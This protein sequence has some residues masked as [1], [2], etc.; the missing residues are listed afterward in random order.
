MLITSTIKLNFTTLY[1]IRQYYKVRVT[2]TI[3][4]NCKSDHINQNMEIHRK[5]NLNIGSYLYNRM[6]FRGFTRQ[7]KID[8]RSVCPRA[9]KKHL[10]YSYITIRL[11]L[12]FGK[13]FKTNL[14]FYFQQAIKR[15]LPNNSTYH[16]VV[17]SHLIRIG[18]SSIHNLSQII[19]SHKHKI[20]NKN[21]LN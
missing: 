20:M 10:I 3:P 5:D 1:D 7:H 13:Y 8:N 18:F 14:Q 11:I 6:K 2:Y 4:S 21:L 16:F 19:P 17:N 15:N 9:S 12:P